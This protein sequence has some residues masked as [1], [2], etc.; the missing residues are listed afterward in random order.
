M[1]GEHACGY[2]RGKRVMHLLVLIS[3]FNAQENRH[4]CITGGDVSYLFDES[5]LA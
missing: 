3:P 2:F 1:H 5:T 4:T